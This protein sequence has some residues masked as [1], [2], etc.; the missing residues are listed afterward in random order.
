MNASSN[1]RLVASARERSGLRLSRAV[2]ASIEPLEARVL[3]SAVVYAASDAGDHSLL[4]QLQGANLVLSD[5]GVVEFSGAFS[6]VASVSITGGAGND[7]L[8][9]DA[10]NGSPLP[11]GGVSFD[12]ASGSNR[13]VL[14]GG[15][16]AFEVASPSGAT[17]GNI[18][19]GG[20]NVAYSNLAHVTDLSPALFFTL[21]TSSGDEQVN[22]VDG[23]VVNGLQTTQVNGGASPRF[24][25]TDF[26]NKHNATI[27]T[28]NGFDT[29]NLNNPAGSSGLSSLTLDAYQGSDV[30]DVAATAPSI[31]TTVTST[32]PFSLGNNTALVGNGSV[33]NILGTLV[34]TNSPG[35]ND[36]SI[37]D[38]ADAT[39]R[40]ATLGSLFD[41]NMGTTVMSVTGLAP[42]TIEVDPFGTASFA[43]NGGSGGNTFNV[44]TD[45]VG[46]ANS[47]NTGAGDDVVN[48]S[49]LPGGSPLSIDG[50][51]GSDAVNVSIAVQN[52]YPSLLGILSVYNSGGVTALSVDTTAESASQTVAIADYDLAIT[53]TLTTGT[54][55]STI[56][57]SLAGGS[58]AVR[59]GQGADRFNVSSTSL[60][61]TLDG[62][63]GADSYAVTMAGLGAAISLLDSGAS[64]TDTATLSGP[65]GAIAYAVG[66]TQTVAGSGAAV[67][68][69]A[70][71]EVVSV[72]G[73]AADDSFTVTPS[74]ST[75][76][77]I[78]GGGSSTAAGNSL[79]LAPGGAANAVL[80]AGPAAGQGSY[81]F[82]NRQPV[83][84][85]N[86]Q[87]LPQVADL[88]LSLSAPATVVEG[89]TLVYSFT[90]T[91]TGPDAAGHVVMN[92]AL[93]GDVVFQSSASTQGSS[94]ASAGVVSFSLGTIAGG[95]TVTGTITVTAGDAGA[96]E[97]VSASA[98]S[99]ASDPDPANNLASA[100]TGV[101]DAPLTVTG[102]MTLS[103]IAGQM[104]ANQTV[105]TFV[106]PGGALDLSHYSAT[107]TWGD[108][109]SSAGTL[110][111]DSTTRSFTAQGAHQYASAG[112]YTVSVTLHHD[113]AADA[114]VTDQAQVSPAQ[115]PPTLS[116]VTITSSNEGGTAHLSGD[117]VASGGGG[118]TLVVNWG[119]NQGSNT[120]MLAA[121]TTHF[122]VLH[123]YPDNPAAPATSFPVTLSIS[124]AN[125]TSTASTAAVVN[126]VAPAAGALTGPTAVVRGQSLAVSGSFTD[127][128]VLDTHTVSF[129][130][131][132]GSAASGAVSETKGSG[133]FSADHVFTA[134]GTYNVVC[135][136]T[137]KD[138]ASVTVKETV[139]VSAILLE[140]DPVFGGT[141]LAIG[142]TTG[143][144]TIDVKSDKG[145]RNLKVTVDGQIDDVTSA[146][147]R[148]VV[149]TQAGNDSI[150]FAKDVVNPVF[151]Y[152]G[153]GN[154][155]I[156]GG[157]GADVF[158][159]GDG[160]DMLIGGTARNILIGGR[161]SDTLV[162]NSNDDI[163]IAGY[164]SLD[165][166]D[167]DLAA[168][169]NEWTRATVPYATR[170]SDLTNGG[171][172][173][174]RVVLNSTTVFNDNARDVIAGSG[175]SDWILAD[176]NDLI[177]GPTARVT[178]ATSSPRSRRAA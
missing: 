109:T 59:T 161:G 135:T 74:A 100:S 85:T 114:S 19:I 90:L 119:P 171:G 76:F 69:D 129:N 11:S 41:S 29:V 159:G 44:L 26:A 40:V 146:V 54:T 155:S 173:N 149:F 51:G 97:T 115:Q 136:I 150:T 37:D 168:V 165:H 43:L 99:D 23:P 164:T 4:L 91:N 170:V 56:N 21:D 101:L 62:G 172:L 28:V 63:D 45:V 81:S 116:N 89:G 39:G 7:V 87:T 2:R 166:N 108:G 75:T 50:Q 52:G 132:D 120:Y 10:S 49:F 122:G 3:L 25:A 12:G 98:S 72:A 48:L 110:S 61:T 27:N 24:V 125:G 6:S 35:L 31:T 84:F 95:A 34:L 130:W 77:N 113:T 105:A 79:A 16:F 141:M 86:I 139:T 36:V 111:F 175:G 65:A 58:L 57:Y 73:G 147:G 123:T 178:Q 32:A 138:G 104:S 1:T 96:I 14:E 88:A 134:S 124:N 55:T 13:L 121:G 68:Y 67:N 106:D 137:D 38:S 70:N 53:T 117:I 163:L 20:A 145:A 143:N 66:P 174:G 158:V 162:G 154:D 22:V 131:G 176:S 127:P 9:I 8:T 92:A 128:G 93:P 5:N 46:A 94:S 112:N 71:M 107:I 156:T 15:S 133:T 140:N 167:A 103:G 177:L 157:G 42:A 152:G 82:S 153:A 30:I 151:A 80:T 169:F 64:G 160:N 148:I 60:P 33:R 118:L 78:D 18:S 17:S 126:N 47:L 144:D 142:G 83:N 102:G